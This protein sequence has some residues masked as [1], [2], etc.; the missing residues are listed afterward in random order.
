MSAISFPNTVPNPEYPFK[1]EYEDNSITS[2][3]EDGTVQSRLKFTRSR[4]TWTLQW[5]GLS[6]THHSTLDNFVVNQ[7][8]HAA[9]IVTWT[10]PNTNTTVNVRCVKYESSMEFIDRWNVELQLQEA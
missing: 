10:I 9:N 2:K 6:D 5:N 1:V 3:F 8:K 4:R 7:A